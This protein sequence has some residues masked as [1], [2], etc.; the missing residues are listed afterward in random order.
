MLEP[1]YRCLFG[2]GLAL[3]RTTIPVFPQTTAS[4]SAS[5]HEFGRYLCLY[6][7][8][9]STETTYLPVEQLHSHTESLVDE[10]KQGGGISY[11]EEAIG[12][13]RE[14]LG[15]CPPGHAK[16]SVS[17]TQLAIHL[18][19]HCRTTNLTVVGQPGGL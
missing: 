7:D 14:A 17:L 2:P 19:A 4:S 3:A 8:V 15:L 12:L 11:I 1:V 13:D 5:H 6:V 16:R 9:Q 18:S 10:F